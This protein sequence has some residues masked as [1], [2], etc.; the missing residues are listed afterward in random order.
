MPKIKKLKKSKKKISKK[1][2]LEKFLKKKL[3]LITTNPKITNK[4]KLR[5]KKF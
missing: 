5:L 4:M 3:N 2:L 1:K